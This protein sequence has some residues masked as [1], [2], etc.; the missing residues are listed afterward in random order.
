MILDAQTLDQI[1]GVDRIVGGAADRELPGEVK[2]ELHA[3]I[4][5]LTTNPVASAGEVLAALVVLRGAAS[6]AA[7]AAGLEI[8]AGGCHPFSRW[9]T[10]PIVKEERYVTFVGWAGISAQRQTVQGLHVHIAVPSA[11]ACWLLLE[12]MLP[13]LPVVLAMSANSPWLAGELTGFASNRA[14]VLTDLPRAGTPPEFGSYAAWEAWVERLVRLRVLEDETRIWWD[15]RPAPRF[16]T[17]EV[18]VADQPTDVRR[19]AAFAGLLQA[20]ADVLL[21]GGPV[22]AASRADYDQNRWAAARFGPAATLIHPDG[23]R[24]ATAAELGHE[25]LD[26]VEPSA[27]RLCSAELLTVLDPAVC[28]AELQTDHASAA[29]ATAD[30]VV[31]SLA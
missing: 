15:V 20:L 24:T 25:L 14:P 17:L 10:Q 7:H 26:L 22:R 4:A 31:R 29:E 16:G 11:D 28:E 5:E 9:Q 23:T 18:R 2:T 21:G 12:A 1:A 8:A 13:W 19:S 6:A 30:L 27:R 3:S